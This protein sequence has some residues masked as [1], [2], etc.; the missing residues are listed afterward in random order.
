MGSGDVGGGD[1][2]FDLA[3]RVGPRDRVIGVDFDETNSER[4]RAAALARHF[5]AGKFGTRVGS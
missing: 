2:T 4:P 5:F 3:E 1:V